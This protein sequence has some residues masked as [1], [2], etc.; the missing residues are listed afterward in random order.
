[1]AQKFGLGK[2]L[3]A[4]ETEIGQS[5]EI[6]AL[7]N[8]PERVLVRQ[9]PLAQIAANPDQPRKTFT[10]EELKDL[11]ESI[12]EHGVLQPI[13]VRSAMGK[14][15]LYEIVAG[16]RRWRAAGM[17]KLGT[18]PALVKNL[19]D[20]SAMEIA[21]IENVQR[22]NLNAIEEA[23]AYRNIMDKAGYT[24]EDLSRL[25]GKSLSYIRNILRLETLPAAVQ[26]MVESGDLS[27]SHAR[28]IAV[29]KNAEELAK[30]ILSE[31]L[32]VAETAEIVKMGPRADTAKRAAKKKTA[33]PFS[34]LRR[35][36]S[37]LAKSLELDV[38][39]SMKANGSGHVSLIFANS[40]QLELLLETIKATGK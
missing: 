23:A 27:A 11:A 37:E 13:I 31:D 12:R 22:E 39:I 26:S 4:L 29:A 38:K 2:T 40:G 36:E 19:E 25:I 3:A 34:D 24:L 10:P 16:E 35:M 14:P 30:K 20:S 8:M 5:P 17:A 32:S 21:L 1:M 6:A 15:H 18:I 9:I 7:G 28:T 33:L